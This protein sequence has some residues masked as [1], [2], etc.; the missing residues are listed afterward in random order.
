MTTTLIEIPGF[1]LDQQV[2]FIGGQGIVRGCKSE[3]K[4]WT[5][6][7]EM[8]LGTEPDFGR[9]GAETMIV[10]T[11]ADLYATQFKERF[12]PLHQKCCSGIK[13]LVSG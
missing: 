4:T 10:L 7:V 1:H 2:S 12:Y 5:Y 13:K 9:I 3:A 11:E 6:F 8:A